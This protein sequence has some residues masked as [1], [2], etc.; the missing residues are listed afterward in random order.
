MDEQFEAQLNDLKTDENELNEVLEQYDL[1]EFLEAEF[2]AIDAEFRELQI[3]YTSLLNTR[4]FLN[5]A[6]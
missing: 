1:D 5:H 2:D 4:K 3:V 6:T